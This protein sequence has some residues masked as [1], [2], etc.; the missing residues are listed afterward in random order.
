MIIFNFFK[1]R[2]FGFAKL[3]AINATILE[4]TAARIFAAHE[5]QR[6][7]TR[8]KVIR[9]HFVQR[10][11]FLL[12]QV[13]AKFATILE[14][15]TARNVQRAR[16]FAGQYADV[17]ILCLV[18]REYRLEQCTRVGVTCAAQFVSVEFFH[19]VAQ[20]HDGNSV[21]KQTDQRKVVANENVSDTLFALELDE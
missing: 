3:L 1:G 2:F 10:G 17:L 9:L 11:L 12:A 18:G 14:R 15:T 6:I 4:R 8:D 13:A 20:I 5:S 21:A 16:N 19:N 7:M